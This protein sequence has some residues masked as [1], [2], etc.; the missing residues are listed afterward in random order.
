MKP[1]LTFARDTNNIKKLTYL[2][3]GV[4]IYAP[5]K[6]RI[7]PMQFERNDRNHNYFIKKLLWIFHLKFQIGRDQ[8][9][10]WQSTT[11]LDRNF[12]QILNWRHCHK[13]NKPFRFFVLESKREVNIK[14][15]TAKNTKKA[16]LKIPKKDTIWWFL[17]Q[18][19]FRL[20]W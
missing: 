9:N 10:Y 17:K 1:T 7:S 4:L 15:E 3:N 2:K 5:K 8:N 6:I 12:K 18:I 19:W 20:C 11:N 16:P 14:H 13:N